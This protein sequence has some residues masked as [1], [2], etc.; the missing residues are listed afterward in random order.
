MFTFK[1]SSFMTKKLIIL[2][3]TVLLALSCNK[4]KTDQIHPQVDGNSLKKMVEEALWGSEKANFN[5][6]G[7]VRS[8]APSPDNANQIFV[9]STQTKS[10]K[11]Y[12]SLLI[13]Y[14]NPSFN[15]LAV[16]DKDL[17]LY[18]HDNSLNG[19]I[20]TKWQTF[21]NKK[22]L[23]ASENFLTKDFLR[24]S[25]LSLYTFIGTKLYLVFRTFTYFD[26]TGEVYQQTVQKINNNTI[27]THITTE[28][29]GSKLNNVTDNFDFIL[30]EDKYISSENVMTNFIMDEIKKADWKLEKP[31]LKKDTIQTTKIDNNTINNEQTQDDKSDNTNNE[32]VKPKGFQI[33]LNAG[34]EAPV[35]GPV[36]EYLISRLDGFQYNNPK[37]GSKLF[38]IPLP[39]GSTSAQFV[40]YKFGKPT[41]GNYKVRQT[42]LIEVGN[43]MIQFF[44]HTCEQ[45]S[46]LLLLKAPT[47]TY[48]NFKNLYNNIVNS[49]FIEC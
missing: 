41:K 25:R 35:S 17:I 2:L 15:I 34:W 29:K 1:D 13:E 16:F 19:N 27:T 43:Y 32:S 7:L 46:Y 12:Y 33:W 24:L 40:K 4:R 47:K 9:D 5:L 42:E 28:V 36:T 20:S 48:D 39:E 49:F 26:K 14:P 3:L 22:Y 8:D 18:L 44:E 21:S 31:E 45:K 6:S 11:K 23:V 10:G 38:V 37:L 30:S